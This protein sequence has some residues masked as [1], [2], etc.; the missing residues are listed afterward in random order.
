MGVL[1][2]GKYSPGCKGSDPASVDMNSMD[3]TA[4]IA[5]LRRA[6]NQTESEEVRYH[7]R[8]ALQLMYVA[9]EAGQPG[10]V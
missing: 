3:P 4:T 7:I 8:E 1:R 5:H 6:L 10:R 2:A 9:D